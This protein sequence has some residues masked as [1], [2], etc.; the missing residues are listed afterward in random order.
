MIPAVVIL[1]LEQ[2]SNANRATFRPIHLPQS[3][4]GRTHRG[5]K[6]AV[7]KFLLGV[8]VSGEPM[9]GSYAG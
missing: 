8:A 6:E 1:F 9:R 5:E 2:E 4:T 3:Q 7:C